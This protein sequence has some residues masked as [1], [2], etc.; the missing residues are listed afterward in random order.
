MID[1]AMHQVYLDDD[2]TAPASAKIFEAVEPL[3]GKIRRCLVDPSTGTAD[4]RAAVEHAR[5]QVAEL[6]NCRRRDRVY[7]GRRKMTT[8]RCLDWWSQ[9]TT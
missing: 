3:P 8:S 9:A 2:A 4:R 5:E 7:L 6:V 1:L